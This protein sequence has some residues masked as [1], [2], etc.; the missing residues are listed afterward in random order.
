MLT[1]NDSITRVTEGNMHICM[2]AYIGCIRCT[3]KYTV[4]MQERGDRGFN[5]YRIGEE[6]QVER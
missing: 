5:L 1:Y 4:Y 2:Y 6:E 3:Y